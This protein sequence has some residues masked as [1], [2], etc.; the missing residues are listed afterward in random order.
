MFARPQTSVAWK[1][2]LY[3]GVVRHRRATPV[4]HEFQYRLFLAYVDLAELEEL[5]GRPGLWSLRRPAIARF[6]REDHLGDPAQSLDRSVRDFVETR[7]GWRP[8][9]PIR[10]L[11]SFRYFGFLMNPVSF[12][13]CFDVGD[14]RL[15]MVVAEVHNTPWNERHCYVLDVRGQPDLNFL[16]VT[17]PKVFHVSPF[18]EMALQY[19]WRLTRPGQRLSIDIAARSATGRPFTASLKLQRTCLSRF[20]LAR[21][22]VQ[23]PLMTLQIFAGIYWQA[24]RLW[25]KRVPHVPHP[26]AAAPRPGRPAPA[27]GATND[28]PARQLEKPELQETIA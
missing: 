27:E 12:Y 20:A 9:G 8:A 28:S 21:V 26:E 18:L 1:S 16:K 6:R 7:T 19:D 23:Y 11:T 13:Y 24:L 22:L 2:C 3:E 4:V 5:F 17:N 14:R 10:L 25:W 15:E